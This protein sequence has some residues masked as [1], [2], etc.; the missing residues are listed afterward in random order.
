MEIGLTHSASG[1]LRVVIMESYYIF[2][3]C[4]RTHVFLAIGDMAIGNHRVSLLC[5]CHAELEFLCLAF[6]F[7]FFN[8]LFLFLS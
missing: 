2:T 8:Y 3:L 5:K 7:W 6:G 1:L 4:S